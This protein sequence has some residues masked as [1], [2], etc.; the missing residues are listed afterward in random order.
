[1]QSGL[2]V[3]MRFLWR[4]RLIHKEMC[5][6]SNELKFCTCLEIK[7]KELIN[8]HKRLEKFHSKKLPKSKEP[9]S[10]IIYEYMG[11]E[12]ND[13]IMG[14]LNMPSNK[15]GFS[16]TEKFVLEQLNN[17]NCFDFEY[18]PKEGDNLQINFQRNKSWIEFLSFIFRKNNWEVDSYDTFT[19]IIEPKNYGILK[20]TQ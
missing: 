17:K 8:I 16:L 11:S 5:E 15:I 9:F 18:Q 3:L 4:N 13:G 14:L 12:Y 2:E 20:V 1:M 10:W 19:E 7:D 6:I